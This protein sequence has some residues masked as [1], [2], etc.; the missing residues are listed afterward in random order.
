MELKEKKCKPC[1]GGVAPYTQERIDEYLPK[2]PG[3]ELEEGKLH[4]VFRFKD[5]AEAGAWLDKVR[6]LADEENHHPDIHWYYNK[7]EIDLYTH[8]INGLS[9]N[10]FILA[11]KI[12]E[13]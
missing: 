2:V 11:A 9:E 6:T 5:F 8:T 12:N 1:E 4:K 3:W 10:D 7:I 13:I